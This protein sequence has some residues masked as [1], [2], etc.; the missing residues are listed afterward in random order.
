MYDEV[1]S[2]DQTHARD[3]RLFREAIFLLCGVAAL[4]AVLDLLGWW[5][6]H[7][8]LV[9]VFHGAV[10][11]KPNTAV[12]ILLLAGATLA[13]RAK[14][15]GRLL[16]K[17][18]CIAVVAITA[19]TLLEYLTG[20]NFGID[21]LLAKVP[22]EAAGDP[23]GRMSRGTAIDGLLLAFGL[24]S[25][26]TAPFGIVAAALGGL[27][28]LSALVGYM[29]DAGPLLGVPLLRSMAPRTAGALLL[30]QIA[31]F[32][33]RPEREPVR[34]L[35][36]SARH[37][38]FGGWYVLG[39]CLLPLLLGMPVSI[40]YR[41]GCSSSR[42]PLPCWS[43]SSSRRKPFSFPATAGLWLP[44]SCGDSASS[45]NVLLSPRR[46]CASTTILWQARRAQHKARRN[47][48][49]SPTRFPLWS[50]ISTQ[51]C[52]TCA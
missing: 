15:R 41:R 1:R 8:A 36:H 50:P 14:G 25:L 12:M 6:H 40:L 31:F 9:G 24:L 21:Q 5:T 49:S 20:H 22:P 45:R 44:L 26:E 18:F 46:T 51:T 10:T 30:L 35:L 4:V 19:A 39:T 42:S 38:R 52:G 17:L 29:F 32:L 23:T 27:I 11:M 16:G 37:H 43:L 48:A 34:S 2:V 13:Q 7:P 3:M 47:T 28:S 33:L